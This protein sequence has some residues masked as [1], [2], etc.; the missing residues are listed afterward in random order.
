ME[1]GV[2]SKQRSLKTKLIAVLMLISTGPAFSEPM[3][4]WVPWILEGHQQ[5]ECPWVMGKEKKK[6]CIW[7]GKLELKAND[8]GAAFTYAVDVYEKRAFIT[9]PGNADHWPTNVQVNGKP[10]PIVE[11]GKLP[12]IAVSSGH[13]DVLGNFQWEKRPGQLA[14]P[15]NA[16]IVSLQVDGKSRVVDRRAGQLIFSSKSDII[17][18]KTNDSLSLE[19]FRLLKDGVPV[20]MIT[21]I[22]LS[23]SGKAREVVFGSVMLADTSVLHIRSAIPARIEADGTMRAQVTPGQHRIQVLARFTGSPETITTSKLTKEW[24]ET[25]YISFKSATSI[26]QAKLS[27]PVSVDTSQISIPPEWVEYPTYRM[28]DG[29]SLN[30]DT[31]FRGDHSPG[32]NELY[33]QRDL[34]LDFD[35]EGITA[36]DRISGEMNKDWRLNAATGTSIGRATVDAAPVLITRDENREGIEVRSPNIELVAVTRTES[37]SGFSASGWD[38]RT[39]QYNATLHLPPAWRVFHA[40]GVDGVW[41]TW[42]SQWDLWDVF[43]VLIIISATRKLIGN[44]VAAIAGGAFL[45]ALHEPGTP[46]L[47]IPLLLVVIALLPVISGKLKFM[48]RSAGLLLAAALAL[49]VISFAVSTFRLAIYPSLERLEIGTYDIAII[50]RPRREWRGYYLRQQWTCQ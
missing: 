42:L 20:T 5:Y 48:I 41:G 18:K 17:Q 28:G 24:P 46:L 14:I 19:V 27:G 44:L 32:A 10:A 39:D 25:E 6:A 4:Q 9:L 31:E 15:R 43:L 3:E 45:I 30:I 2:V 13:Y 36:L 50:L 16:A 35:G 38:A 1:N 22:S 40:S 11:R 47:V 7:P 29:E 34:W 12:H 37:T 21:D 49:S 26:R 23:V 33:V 8:K